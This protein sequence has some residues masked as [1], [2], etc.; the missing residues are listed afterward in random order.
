[1]R[2]NTRTAEFRHRTFVG[3][4]RLS[5]AETTMGEIS[6][7]TFEHTDANELVRK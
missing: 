4:G 3:N 2:S 1:M 5:C 6:G 7:K